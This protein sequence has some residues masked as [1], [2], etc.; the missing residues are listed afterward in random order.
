[1]DGTWTGG[2]EQGIAMAHYLR[3]VVFKCT[4]CM[5]TDIY[6]GRV[7]DHIKGVAERYRQHLKAGLEPVFGKEPSKQCMG[8]NQVFLTR[9]NSADKHLE[10]MVAEGPA[11]KGAQETIMRRFSLAPSTPV[12]NSTGPVDIQVERS[13]RKR[14]RHRKRRRNR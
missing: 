4:A 12:A 3:K 13:G 2:I 14:S 10:Q 7:A 1:V 8:C 6:E 9:K 5:F 11:H